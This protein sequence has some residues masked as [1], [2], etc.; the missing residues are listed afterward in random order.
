MFCVH[1]LFQVSSF[2]HEIES[3]KLGWSWAT[4][5]VVT[6]LEK[7]QSTKVVIIDFR[8]NFR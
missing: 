8:D 6:N 7:D 3:N 1:P 2:S 4:E 5:W